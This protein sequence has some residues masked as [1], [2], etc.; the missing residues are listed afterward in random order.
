MEGLELDKKVKFDMRGLIPP[1]NM[2]QSTETT[3]ESSNYSTDGK[4]LSMSFHRPKRLTRCNSYS[5]FSTFR[6]IATDD[7]DDSI[8]KP[9]INSRREHAQKLR[10][11]SQKFIDLLIDREITPI[12]RSRQAS[13]DIA[14]TNNNKNNNK[15]K[16]KKKN[17]KKK[18]KNKKT[19]YNDCHDSCNFYPGSS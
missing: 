19:N 9:G 1:M 7:N 8:V 5:A 2:R 17:K 14:S 11:Y 16:N 6:S 3:T 4:T 15:N 13:L 18:K 10:Q 12:I